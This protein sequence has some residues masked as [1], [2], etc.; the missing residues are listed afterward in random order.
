MIYVY[1]TAVSIG[2]IL[3]IGFGI[4]FMSYMKLNTYLINANE[5]PFYNLNGFIYYTNDNILCDKQ[6]LNK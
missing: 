4:T 1:N 6:F 2:F 5:L 3:R